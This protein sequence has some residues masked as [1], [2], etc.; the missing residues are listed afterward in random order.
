V[1]GLK[2]KD[3]CFAGLVF[4]RGWGVWWKLMEGEDE[5]E[6]ATWETWA[7]YSWDDLGPHHSAILSCQDMRSVT[8]ITLGCSVCAQACVGGF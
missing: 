3:R 7:S 5:E 6:K 2:I 8:L 4:G 1:F